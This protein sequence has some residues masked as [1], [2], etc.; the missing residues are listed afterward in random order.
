MNSFILNYLENDIT[1]RAIMLKGAWG[2]GKSYYIK[3]TLKTFLE[4]KFNG[5]YKCVIVS[6]NGLSDISEISKAIY[7][8]L[9]TIKKS[10]KSETGNTAK[11]VGKII[12]KTICN[13][14]INKIGFDIGS[15]SDYDFQEVY[16]SINL[17]GKLIVLEDIERTQIDII[18]LLGY[19][20]NMCENDGVKVMLVA[21]E[22]EL[23]TTYEKSDDEGK[24]TKDYTDSA[25]AYKRA[26][27]KTVGDTIHFICDYKTTI[28]QIIDSFGLFL[29]KYKTPECAE[30]INIIFD[31]MFSHNLRAFIYC[32]QKI[33]EIFEF[34]QDNDIYVKDEIQKIIFYG[35]VA[36]TQRQSK[37][38]VLQ[39]ERDT[40]L[41]AKL[42]FNEE[43]PLFRFCYDYIIY[44]IIS[45]DDIEKIVA[46]FKKYL[47]EGK[48]N[49]ERDSDLKIIKNYYVK[50][51]QEVIN[52]IK[53]L[54]Q[55][56]KNGDIPYYDY[57][58]LMY[59]L[60]AIKYDVGIDF[61]IE[62]IENVIIE[63]LKEAPD[64]INIESLFNSF[65]VLHQENAIN[66]LE[67]I[68][69]KMTEALEDKDIN[70]F[71]YEPEKV[72][73]FYKKNITKLKENIQTKGFACNLDINRFIVMLK[74]C[75]A[76]QIDIIRKIFLDL[77][78]KYHPEILKADISA[79]KELSNNLSSLLEYEQYDKIQKMQV[80]LFNENL[81]D[82][83]NV[84]NIQN[85]YSKI[86]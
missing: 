22:S 23:L 9:R 7:M 79:I 76:E 52:A 12:G 64:E 85:K 20:N 69:Q 33:K 70:V 2:S 46:F 59:Y 54:P 67:S 32:C 83:I 75:S 26:K 40:Y 72:N 65:Y 45:K 15:I 56:L 16:E 8:E 19:V 21:N 74:N 39:F 43:Y 37:G 86:Q 14:L 68:K 47:K 84:L 60:V 73:D 81:N 5:K 24:T 49:S 41:S 6:L 78:D 53:N 35:C 80:D 66:A 27:E 38:A 3:H 25:I 30:D 48:W 4:D 61:N 58:C 18:E 82:I 63:Q 57:G 13:G 42:G 51:E 28:Q 1:G 11:V 10:P 34:I 36:F 44:Q 50:T 71:P 31:M 62:N 17:D 55:K 77:Y 29:Q